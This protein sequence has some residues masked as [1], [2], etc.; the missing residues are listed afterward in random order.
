R[1]IVPILIFN[2][3]TPV[4]YVHDT[5]WYNAYNVG[6]PLSSGDTVDVNN[7]TP[8]HQKL[9]QEGKDAVSLM[10][11]QV[12]NNNLSKI[13]VTDKKMGAFYTIANRTD[14]SGNRLPLMTIT[15]ANPQAEIVVQTNQQ[16]MEQGRGITFENDKRKIINK[17]FI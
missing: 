16:S 14:A 5:T 12:I 3:S 17:A 2:G 11:E 7:I 15:E 4:A 10:R 1:D 6:D 9:I 13:T 8:T